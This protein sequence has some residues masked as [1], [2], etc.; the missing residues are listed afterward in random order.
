MFNEFLPRLSGT[1]RLLHAAAGAGPVDIYSNGNPIAMNL[2]FGN[3]TEYKE[4][5][6]GKNEVQFYKAGTYDQPILT[7]TIEVI[8]NTT[9][10]VSLVLLESDLQLLTLKDGSP[11]GS[12]TESYLRFINLSPD[13]PLLTLS[14]PNGNTLFNG[15]EYLET[16]GYYPLSPG[17]YDFQVQA[18]SAS[19]IRKTI[20][21]IRLYGGFFHTLYIIGLVDGEPKI[22]YLYEQDGKRV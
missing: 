15:V 20:N 9:V 19:G 2:A 3:I 1:V 14:L 4:I 7:E 22:G 6:T 16:T 5:S 11:T 8:P 12:T 13:S 17:L 21:D 10:T 18:T